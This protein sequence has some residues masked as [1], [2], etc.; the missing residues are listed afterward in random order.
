MIDSLNLLKE[1]ME[2]LIDFQDYHKRMSGMVDPSARDLILKID[3][4]LKYNSKG[5]GE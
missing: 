2:E 5:G 1:C 3:K 4:F